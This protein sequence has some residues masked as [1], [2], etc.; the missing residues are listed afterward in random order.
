MIRHVLVAFACLAAAAPRLHRAD[1]GAMDAFRLPD[2]VRPVS[3]A[4]EVAT[5]LD[6]FAYT[7]R[8]SVVV[9]ATA[10][11]C[12]IVLNAKD[13]RATA[14]EVLDR[15]L[16][17]NVPVAGFRPVRRNEQLVIALNGTR[18]CLTPSRTYV[19]RVAFEGSLADDMSGYYRSSYRENNVTKYVG[20]ISRFHCTS[21]TRSGRNRLGPFDVLERVVSNVSEY[22]VSEETVKAVLERSAPRC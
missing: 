5:D 18:K 3:Y 4:L 15:H 1:A 17:E 8:V 12:R 7:G 10:R 22:R 19:V 13:V 6:A 16:D 11:T 9:R 20:P 2:D 14:V 21:A